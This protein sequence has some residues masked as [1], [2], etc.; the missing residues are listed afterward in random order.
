M[1]PARGIS[2]RQVCP[3]VGVRK[4]ALRVLV[5]DAELQRWGVN[6][7]A[8][9]GLDAQRGQAQLLKRVRELDMASE[10]RRLVTAYLSQ[11]NPRVG[12]AS[13]K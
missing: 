13:P 6:P 9:G 11:A 1:V 2:Q 4:P 8:A 3:D 7:A 10:I 5:R 12:A